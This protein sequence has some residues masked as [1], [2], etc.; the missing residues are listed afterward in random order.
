VDSGV[1]G[2]TKHAAPH[3]CL[4]RYAPYALMPPVELC[5]SNTLSAFLQIHPKCSRGRDRLRLPFALAKAG[6]PQFSFPNQLSL[7]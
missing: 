4:T 5:T 6:W 2:G 1:R 3:E 7:A